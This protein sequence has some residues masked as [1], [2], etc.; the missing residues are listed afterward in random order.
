SCGEIRGLS[1]FHFGRRR[2]RRTLA[3]DEERCVFLLGAVEVDLFAKMGNERARAHRQGGFRI[4]FRAGADPPR[5]AE[6]GDETVVR[7]EVR[8]AEVIAAEPFDHL[9]V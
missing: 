2:G 4:E 8:T 1:L 6:Y 9:H 5:A 7:M 3:D